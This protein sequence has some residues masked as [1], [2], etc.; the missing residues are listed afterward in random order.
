[1]GEKPLAPESLPDDPKVL[2]DLILEL[3][4]QNKS[5]QDQNSL[6]V[7]C[8]KELRQ[9]RFGKKKESGGNQFQQELDFII[10]G[11]AAKKPIPVE[12]PDPDPAPPPES[13][14][15]HGRSPIPDHLFREVNVHDVPESD[16]RC[17][18]CGKELVFIGEEV[19]ERVEYVPA[20][21]Y[22]RR[23]VRR[24]YG[25]PDT[26]CRGDIVVAE[27]PP[28]AVPKCKAAEGMLAFV[29][30][31]KY[32]AHEP[33][34]RL[35]E[36]LRNHGF[37]VNRSTLWEWT[38]GTAEAVKPIYDF[39]AKDV[40]S[41]DVIGSDD[42]PVPLWDDE[43]GVLKQGRQWVY[44]NDEHTVYEH[45]E[46]RRMEHP[47]RFL[48]D[49]EGT[50]IS[51]AYSGYRS[52]ARASKG[53]LINAF[54]MAHARRKFWNALDTD[55]QRAQVALAYIRSLYKVE[56]KAKEMEPEDRKALRQKESVPIL[57]NFKEWMGEQ[58]LMV[59]P[60]SPIGKALAYTLNNWAELNVFVN[61]GNVSIDN[62][63]SERDMRRWALGRK[64]WLRFHSKRGGQ[65]GA[66]LASLIESCRRHN[67]NPYEY[68][69]DVLLRLPTHKASKIQELT[70]AHWT[71]PSDSS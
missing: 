28:E 16:R 54:C 23:K 63:Q 58:G 19:S 59:L 18:C 27:N 11:M 9:W 50:V 12:K 1:M 30:W 65:V 48:E 40:K 17:K 60:K 35:E 45:T 36:H 29:A 3:I 26:Q 56:K 49:A 31:R 24:K 55:K 8:V 10:E 71:P 44:N 67:K 13:R 39:M 47:E 64:N 20:S 41:S 53:R 62:N 14:K 21:V 38:K 69:R 25:C 68:L 33:L 6:L 43:H 37:E 7:Q 22:A 70:P 5:L 15:G 4:K 57:R 51:D 2:R 34:Y 66:I 52:I 32:G 61:D 42:S 46:N